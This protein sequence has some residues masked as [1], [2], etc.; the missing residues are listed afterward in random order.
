[1]NELAAFDTTPEQKVA[2]S[3]PAG[4]PPSSCIGITGVIGN[5]TTV[6]MT[7]SEVARN[8]LHIR[9]TMLLKIKDNFLE[10]TISLKTK[11]LN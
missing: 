10:A 5:M 8:Q 1:M 3:N 4:V 9:A 7:V 6:H 11:R 2:V